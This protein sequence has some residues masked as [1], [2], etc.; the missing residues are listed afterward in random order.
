MS[1][2]LS[3]LPGT[4]PRTLLLGALMVSAACSSQGDPPAEM[5][6]ESA[7]DPACA[8]PLGWWESKDLDPLFATAGGPAP[9]V[10]CQFHLWAW[11]AFVHFTQ[12]DS[13]GQPGFISLPTPSQLSTGTA[14]DGRLRLGP[15]DVKRSQ[16]G[17]ID[18]AGPRG[19][20]VDQNGRA[21]YYS[22]HMDQAYFDFAQPLYGVAQFNAASPDTVFPVGSTVIKAS[23]RQVGPGE[24]TSGMFTTTAD[25]AKLVNGTGPGGT[26][27]A[28]SE[29]IPD[30]QVALVGMHIVSVLVDHPEFAWATFE[31]EGN[32]PNLP[33]GMNPK[34][35]D[36][37][38]ASSY[39]FY[40]GGTPANQCN[41]TA[42]GT[43]VTVNES[44]QICS[45][46][47]QVFR[48]FEYGDASPSRVADIDQVNA[49]FQA[50]LP[51]QAKTNKRLDPVFAAYTLVGTVW[52]N[53]NTLKPGLS[54]MQSTSI[55][56]TS[57]MNS[58]ME[59]FV[60]GKGQNCFSCH[61]TAS[62]SGPAG[63]YQASDLALSHVLLTPF[64]QQ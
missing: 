62:G 12:L 41:I 14:H 24:D 4:S 43:S 20:L 60:Q 9:T 49:E 58:T 6:V 46:I 36:A 19:V 64:F 16:V 56:S 48:E 3:F 17:E 45:P 34:S 37:V 31:L 59:T 11:S 42:E 63:K 23:W 21:V 5:G 10:D 53:V 25:I 52:Q 2:V 22:T 57:L 38:S 8:V 50:Q 40:A 51:Q 35:S 30:V 27:Q 39:T 33:V 7:T 29:Y 18:Q 15:R 47:I 61:N 26:V 55:G 44:T 13:S 28:S 54:N 1:S 32:S